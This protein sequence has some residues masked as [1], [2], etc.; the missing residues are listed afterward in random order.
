MHIAFNTSEL[1]DQD[2]AVLRALLGDAPAAAP[3]AEKPAP[4]KAAP[5]PKPEP[6]KE[7]EPVQEEAPAEPEAEDDL[8]G[9]DE[10]VTRADAVAAATKLVT[11]GEQAKVKDALASVGAKRVSE[12][13]DDKLAAFVAALS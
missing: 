5:A 12:V 13:A 10:V 1:T 7:P 8:L 6:V 3:K 11:S 9:G 2:R 4:A